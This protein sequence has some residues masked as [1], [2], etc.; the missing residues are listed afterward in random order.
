MSRK[1][2]Q[3]ATREPEVVSGARVPRVEWEAGKPVD[4]HQITFMENENDKN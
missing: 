2:T 4:G 3:Y 1:A